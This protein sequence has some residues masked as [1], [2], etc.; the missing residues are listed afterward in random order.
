MK[1]LVIAE[2]YCLIGHI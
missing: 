1:Q 2:R